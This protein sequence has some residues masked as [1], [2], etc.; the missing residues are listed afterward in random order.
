MSAVVIDAAEPAAEPV[1]RELLGIA[2]VSLV[3][4]LLLAAPV[5]H[6]HPVDSRLQ[7]VVQPPRLRAFLEGDVHRPPDP[8]E[9]LEDRLFPRGKDASRQDPTTPS[10]TTATVLAW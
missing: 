9:Q 8:A 3:A 4:L 10:C 7:Q 1:I 6:H 5:A 2:V